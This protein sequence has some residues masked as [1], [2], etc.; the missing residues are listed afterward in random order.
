[1]KNWKTTIL[2]VFGAGLILARSK[3][4]IDDQTS[5]FIGA[6]LTALFGYVTKDANST[7]NIGGGGIQNPPKPN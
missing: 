7:D 1:M 4:W 6:T 2:G 3:G 5:V